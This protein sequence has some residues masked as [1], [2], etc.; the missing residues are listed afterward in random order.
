MST[1]RLRLLVVEDNPADADFIWESLQ[2]V[3]S[4]SF[5][6]ESVSRLSAALT[7]LERR[8]V[9][10]VLVDLG[11][12]D[13]QGL[14]TLQTLRGAVRDIPVVVLTGTDDQELAVA[15]V[16]DGA[17]DFLVKGQFNGRML[18]RSIRYAM[19]RM[20]TEQAR[21]ALEGQLRQS[22]KMESVGLLAGGVAHEFN[23]MMAVVLGNAE[24]ALQ[25]VNATQPLHANLMAIESAARRCADLTRQLLA[26]ARKQMVAPKVL[27]LN[28]SV[29]AMLGRL[30]RSLGTEVQIAWQPQ[31]TLW[32]VAVDPAQLEQILTNLCSNARAAMTSPGTLTIATANRV[33]DEP[34]CVTNTD[35][36]PGEYVQLAVSDSGSGMDEATLGRIFE[37]FFTT[38]EVGQGT[39]LGLAMVYGAVRQNGGFITVSSAP[40]QG[41]TFEIY[42]P[43]HS[44]DAARTKD[45]GSGTH[46]K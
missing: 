36:V 10:L 37:P 5:H 31:A 27:D 11:L 24:L 38:R 23:N 43:R 32:P 44:S 45:G 29:A 7:R 17:Q 26:F 34:F 14:S 4:V 2:E 39:G 40:E 19:E 12:P 8:D 21:K 15:A 33:V 46:G 30:Q 35:A 16:R 1:E 6:I 28:E 41:A 13:S 18:N 42:L 9:D 25:Q 3:G 22:Q 20:R